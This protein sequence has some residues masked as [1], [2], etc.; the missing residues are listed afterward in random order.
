VLLEN[1]HITKGRGNK[2]GAVTAASENGPLVLRSLTELEH[3]EECFVREFGGH[4]FAVRKLRLS[5]IVDHKSDRETYHENK[6][7]CKKTTTTHR[8]NNRGGNKKIVTQG[9]EGHAI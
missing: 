8:V 4:L 2:I 1:S 6:E 9:E 7:N 3:V 5:G